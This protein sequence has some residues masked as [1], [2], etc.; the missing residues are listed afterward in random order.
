MWAEVDLDAISHN[1]NRIRER[2]GRPIKLLVPIKANAYG[3]GVVAVSRYLET[4]GVDGLATANVDDALAARRAGVTL[5]IVPSIDIQSPS[6][7][8]RPSAFTVR[9][10]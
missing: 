5:P 3:H 2:A 1:I 10:W 7:N 8:V 6:V 9:A 4:L